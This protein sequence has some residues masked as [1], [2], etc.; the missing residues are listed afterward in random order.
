M[1][2]RHKI[3]L[4]Y[5]AFIGSAIVLIGFFLSNLGDINTRYADLMKN[6]Q[7]ILLLLNS[8]RSGVQRQIVAV[9]TFQV[10]PDLSLQYEFLDARK[11]ETDALQAIEPLLV[12]PQDQETMQNVTVSLERYDDIARQIMTFPSPPLSTTNVISSTADLSAAGSVTDTTT[13]ALAN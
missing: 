7:R 2:I 9:R 1:R 5:L 6:D 11:E 4:G 3:L 13:S 10:S 8:L 12:K